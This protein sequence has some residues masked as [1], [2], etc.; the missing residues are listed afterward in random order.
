MARANYKTGTVPSILDRLFDEQPGLSQEP[1]TDRL[2]SVR[3]FE[4]AVARDL[5]AL[6]NTRQETLEEL[7][8][9]FTELERSLVCYGLPDFTS[10]SLDDQDDRDRIRRA[11]EKTIATFEPRLQRVRVTMETS[12]EKD[13]GL[14]FRID[15]LLRVEPAPEPVT[16]DAFLQLTTQE[17]MVESSD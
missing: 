1:V 6:L 11:V 4:K 13:R 10:F 3:E 14:R 5:E 8:T 12:R 9:E 7:P 17:Y 15:A 2:Q 16:F